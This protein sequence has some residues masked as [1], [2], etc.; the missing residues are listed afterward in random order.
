M[1]LPIES[2][3]VKVNW[4]VYG[5]QQ[6]EWDDS[7][8]SWR[9]KLET[10]KFNGVVSNV[11]GGIGKM[12]GWWLRWWWISRLMDSS[13]GSCEKIVC[14]CVSVLDKVVWCVSVDRCV[15]VARVVGTV[16]QLGRACQRVVVLRNLCCS[17]EG[18]YRAVTGLGQDRSLSAGVR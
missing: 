2:E 17:G 7:D 9:K 5:V 16:G 8:L 14:G 12:M 15:K 10:L 3:K 4:N 11:E 1:E 6:A 13:R 18:P